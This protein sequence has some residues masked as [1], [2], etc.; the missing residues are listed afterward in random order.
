MSTTT[1]GISARLVKHCDDVRSE[2]IPI[3]RISVYPEKT[4]SRYTLCLRIR[5]EMSAWV[6]ER[7]DA[8]RFAQ[9]YMYDA[10]RLA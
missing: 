8:G 3:A 1:S 6:A 10:L 4:T 7:K 5:I 9:E 2:R